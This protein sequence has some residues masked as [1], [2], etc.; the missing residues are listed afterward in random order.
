MNGYV[1]DLSK[2]YVSMTNSDGIEEFVM[3][4]QR[5]SWD[6]IWKR[7]DVEFKAECV[8]VQEFEQLNN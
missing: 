2:F 4:E 6:E 7:Q 1:E 3:E 8:A 5:A